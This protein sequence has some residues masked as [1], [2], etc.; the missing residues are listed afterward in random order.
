MAKKNR[1]RETASAKSSKFP[2]AQNSQ[3]FDWKVVAALFWL[4]A[5]IVYF[6]SFTLPNNPN[7]S[8]Y[9][10]LLYLDDL[11]AGIFGLVSAQ[12]EIHSGW[13][14]L[15][16]RFD[17]LLTA[18]F[19]LTGA[20]AVGSLC[21]RLLL[22][23]DAVTSLERFVFSIGIGLSGLSLLTL[24]AGLCGF[25]NLWLLGGIIL[26]F[27]SWAG[28]QAWNDRK[29]QS[30]SSHAS[31]ESS[32]RQTIL[33]VISLLPFLAVMLLG[34]MLPSVD[35]DVKEYHLQGPKEFYQ[36][37]QVS[38][39]PHNVY[40][41]FPFL[42]EMLTLLGMVLRGDWYWGALVGK[43]VLMSFAPLTALGLYAAG[44]R[45][46]S[47]LTGWF[48]ALIFLSTPWVYR[49]AI[50]AYVEGGLSCYLFLTFISLMI[51]T[52]KEF[53]STCRTQG[54]FITGI[55]AGS[56]MACKYPGVLQVVIPLGLLA[57]FLFWKRSVEEENRKRKILKL[58]LVYSAG[59]MIA[60]GPWLAKNRVETGNPV[61]P[62]VY[63]AFGGEDWDA[64]LN[65]KWTRAH[66]PDDYDPA[67]L[68]VKFIDVIAKS[69][70]QSALLFGLAPLALLIPTTRR[71]VGIGWCYVF[72]LFLSW[73]IFTHRLD[74]FWVPLIPVVA[75]LAGIGWNWNETR[76][77]RIGSGVLIA[78]A[79]I[80][81]FGFMTSTLSGYNAYLLDLKQTR[82]K[83]VSPPT[84]I[85]YKF[86]HKILPK[87]AK[88][89]MVGEAQVFD[90]RFE[91]VYNTVFDYSIFQEWIA[92]PE[93]GVTEE[94]LSLRST[95]EIRDKL[96][97]EGITDIYVNWAEILRYRTTYGYTKFV[98]PSRF[99]DLVERGIL[100]PP[101]TVTSQWWENLS[102]SD[103]NVI[104]TWDEKLLKELRLN[105]ESNKLDEAFIASQVFRVRSK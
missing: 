70:W 27:I 7:F 14:Y 85:Q 97:K 15:T 25:L 94:D 67:D 89:L 52:A 68:A 92:E 57:L 18:G 42:T 38:F 6:F 41:S 19:I 64:E 103:K 96:Q 39:L 35:F 56:A 45:W 69:D 80:F 60:I 54:I 43:T 32:H 100:E 17:I 13:Q 34:A 83:L 65:E 8:R 66:S 73:W 11:Y 88:V 37:G 12:G 87:N 104:N 44:S 4:A 47:P 93:E 51:F 1:Q 40:T 26:G 81:N 82:E 98:S 75:L 62:L 61:Y 16:Q 5:F 22:P 21:L 20:W 105:T 90:A 30:E 9:G 79:L 78:V 55:L 23:R 58:A 99:A 49:L 24:G 10:L 101:K 3:T 77:W 72:F 86:L 59:V 91:V 71:F 48:A 2:V 46:F 95:K 50:I 84:S 63:S 102:R 76:L 28:F 53:P 29:L 33:A 36:N 31:L 74:R